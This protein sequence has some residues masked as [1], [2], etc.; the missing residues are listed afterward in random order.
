MAV[1]V[2]LAGWRPRPVS[3]PPFAIARMCS[4]PAPAKT[5]D[6]PGAAN[7]LQVG[8]RPGAEV[9]VTIDT[10]S[11]RSMMLPRGDLAHLGPAM[12]AIWPHLGNPTLDTSPDR[13]AERAGRAFRRKCRRAGNPTGRRPDQADASPR[14]TTSC[15]SIGPRAC[16]CSSRCPGAVARCQVPG[17]RRRPWRSCSLRCMREEL[18]AE[19]EQ[20]VI[21]CHVRSLASMSWRTPKR[22]QHTGWRRPRAAPSIQTSGDLTPT[23]VVRSP[24]ESTPS[25]CL[26]GP[27]RPGGSGILG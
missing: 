13:A 19:A 24:G 8:A 25:R 23:P 7:G 10:R 2:P 6:W 15:R 17:R 20:H 1:A 12:A 18:Q 9:I 16:D 3:G 4:A 14:R 21:I 22:E 5:P 11:R 26:R 27:C